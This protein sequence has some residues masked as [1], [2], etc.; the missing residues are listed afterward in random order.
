MGKL[1]L[2]DRQQAVFPTKAKRSLSEAQVDKHAEVQIQRCASLKSVSSDSS[3]KTEVDGKLRMLSVGI[4]SS[5]R[6]GISFR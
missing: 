3:L 6:R 4:V 1:I 2:L 5:S